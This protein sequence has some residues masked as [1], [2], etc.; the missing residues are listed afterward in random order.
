MDAKKQRFGAD[1][2][3]GVLEG[4]QLLLVAKGKKILRFDLGE[5]TDPEALENAMLGPSGNL[6]A[7]TLRV[8]QR[9]LVGFHGEAY[10]EVFGS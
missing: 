3:P 4:V 6:R 1:D 7:P 8:G 10:N 2:L 9:M 5:S